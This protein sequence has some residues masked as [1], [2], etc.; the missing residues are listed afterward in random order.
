MANNYARFERAANIGQLI[1]HLSAAQ[2]GLF[3]AVGVASLIG[4]K[5]KADQIEALEKACQEISDHI[6][7]EWDREFKTDGE[8]VPEVT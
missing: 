7:K 3:M 4:D 2:T 8:Q 6:A 5:S 1:G